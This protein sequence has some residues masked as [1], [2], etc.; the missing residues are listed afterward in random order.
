M[1]KFS[2]ILYLHCTMGLSLL[3]AAASCKSTT[4]RMHTNS[5]EVQTQKGRDAK[6]T[7]VAMHTE[8]PPSSS[9]SKATKRPASADP[10]L[11]PGS[12]RRKRE[13]SVPGINATRRQ[14]DVKTNASQPA[15]SLLQDALQR[16]VPDSGAKRTIISY[17]DTPKSLCEELKKAQ[18]IKT[19]QEIL[20][21]FAVLPQQGRSYSAAAL[22][23]QVAPSFLLKVLEVIKASELNN[24]YGTFTGP[25]RKQISGLVRNTINHLTTLVKKGSLTL[26]GITDSFPDFSNVPKGGL[27]SY[28]KYNSERHLALFISV[29]TEMLSDECLHKQALIV[30]LAAQ[31]FNFCADYAGDLTAFHSL[32][33]NTCGSDNKEIAVALVEKM[34]EVCNNNHLNANQLVERIL[35]IVRE[36]AGATAQQLETIYENGEINKGDFDKVMTGSQPRYLAEIGKLLKAFYALAR[37]KNQDLIKEIHEQER[38]YILLLQYAEAPEYYNKQARKHLEITGQVPQYLIEP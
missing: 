29:M 20:E 13:V 11:T 22:L 34:T 37:K 25:V 17:L 33:N 32:S 6:K 12:K 8:N 3:L 38:G 1:N 18:D 16:Y 26:E 23:K 36:I 27:S 10:Q 5:Q 35:G 4:L 2:K 9:S 14:E 28:E 31:Y 24:E 30:H 19:C 7:A 15:S 21:G